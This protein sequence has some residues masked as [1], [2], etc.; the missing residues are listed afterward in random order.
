MVDMPHGTESGTRLH[1]ASGTHDATCSVLLKYAS[2]K[3]SQL[4]G[5]MRILSSARG[6]GARA[7]VPPTR[8]VTAKL[9][10]I[11]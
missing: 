11:L 1:V 4:Y 2:L 8:P 7:A 10:C 5:S 6:G 3:R 9:E